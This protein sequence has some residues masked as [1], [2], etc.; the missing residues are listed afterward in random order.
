MSFDDEKNSILEAVDNGDKDIANLLIV[1]Y[2]LEVAQ[3]A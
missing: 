1:K 2:G 3:R